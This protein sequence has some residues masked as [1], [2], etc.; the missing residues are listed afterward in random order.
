M[1][2]FLTNQNWFRCHACHANNQWK[3]IVLFVSVKPSICEE[4]I[5]IIYQYI[6]TNQIL[7]CIVHTP[8]VPSFR[9]YTLG[10]KTSGYLFFF[11]CPAQL[12]SERRCR[13]GRDFF[14]TRE[15]LTEQPSSVSEFWSSHR[16]VAGLARLSVGF[17][18]WRAGKISLGKIP[19]KLSYR[20]R[21]ITA[22]K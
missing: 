16:D 14:V 3:G 12:G 7:F 13:L 17:L 20:R 2:N 15:A 5:K 4:P 9:V 21:L 11:L 22:P 18:W 6:L 10:A 8:G 19:K 1:F